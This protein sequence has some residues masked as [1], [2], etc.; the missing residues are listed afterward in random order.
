VD[1]HRI[2]ALDAR[3]GKRLWEFAAGARIDSPPTYFRGALVFGS[4][5]GWVYSVRAT[6]GA[7]V[8]RL[9][10]APR[11]RLVGAFGQLE[12]AWPVHGSV[13]VLDGIAYFAAGRSSYL[14]GGLYLYGIDAASGEVRHRARLQGPDYTVDNIE[15]NYRLP[16]GTLPDVMQS[17]G[18]SIFMRDT[19]FGPDLK[20]RGGAPKLRAGGGFLDDT[21]FKRMPWRHSNCGYGRLIVYDG[22]RAYCVRMFDSLQGLNPNVYFTPGAKG[23]LLTAQETTKRTARWS[24]RVRIRVRAMVA[25]DGALCIAGPPDVVDDKDPLGAFEGRKGGVLRLLAAD[26]G[27]KIAEHTLDSPP[28]FNGMA[29]AAGR[30]YIVTEDGSVMCIGGK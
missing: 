7:L 8:W 28:V 18:S 29:A 20:R 11:E 19:S 3:N 17:D 1:A 14:D 30:L 22:E 16:M 24:H 12:S 5:D 25:T 9:R 27:E 6:G 4:A 23:Y 26:S 21:Y 2:V 10:A 15:Q 13:L